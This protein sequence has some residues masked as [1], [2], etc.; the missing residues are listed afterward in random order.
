MAAP[1]MALILN[2]PSVSVKPA[3][4]TLLTPPEEPMGRAYQW[5]SAGR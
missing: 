5:C 1:T 2:W 4:A 3:L